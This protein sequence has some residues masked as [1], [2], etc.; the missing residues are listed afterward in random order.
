MAQY[1][2]KVH[3]LNKRRNPEENT[4]D[5]STV[6]GQVKEGTLLE[7]TL[8]DHLSNGEWYMDGKGGYYWGGG[9]EE[10]IIVNKIND[11][12][13]W[14]KDLGISSLSYKGDG[15][16][17]AILDSGLHLNHIDF[18]KENIIS[19]DFTE[20]DSVEDFYGHGTHCAG[21]IIG[22]GTNRIKG[23]APN[24]TL[25]NGKVY[26]K[27]QYYFPTSNL[28]NALKWAVEN[29]DIISISIGIADSEWDKEFEEIID[30]ATNKNKIIVCAIGNTFNGGNPTG[31]YPAK[32]PNCISVGS[33]SNN[34]TISSFTKRFPNLD[35]CLPGEDITSTFIDVN[36]PENSNNEYYT[37]SGTSLS[38]PLFAGVLALKKQK[39]KD[40][41]LAD[42][43]KFIKDIS[44]INN[45]VGFQFKSIKNN[46]QL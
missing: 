26:Y 4:V 32:Y 8:V 24:V 10:A 12:N 39:N 40:F 23:V 29:A 44:L 7:L 20:S 28:K 25:Y 43:R 33:L 46:I 18:K 17:V 27:G 38:T 15:V 30:Q 2:V 9:I 37:L 14:I 31:D 22:Q 1:R 3:L 34:L 19:Q 35:I 5:K 16:K 42:A 11:I 13:A 41:G 21:I 6:T 45:D 36:N